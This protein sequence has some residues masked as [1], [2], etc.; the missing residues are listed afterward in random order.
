MRT[1]LAARTTTKSSP[2]QTETARPQSTGALGTR[3]GTTVLLARALLLSAVSSAS[4]LGACGDDATPPSP[5]AT[6]GAA[7]AD[8]GGAGGASGA[9]AGGCI[10]VSFT[11]LGYDPFDKRIGFEMTPS[12]GDGA[13]YRASLDLRDTASGVFQLGA[14]PDNGNKT[15]VHCLRVSAL[16]ADGTATTRFFQRAGQLTV[17]RATPGE[18]SYQLGGVT[19][20]EVAVA[21]DRTSTAVEGGRCLKLADASFTLKDQC[22]KDADCGDSTQVCAPDTLTCVPGCLFEKDC[23]SGAFC[24][25]QSAGAQAGACVEKCEIAST[26]TCPQG[27]CQQTDKS[28]TLARCVAAT[29]HRSKGESCEGNL[30]GSNCGPDLL[31]TEEGSSTA[32]D[33]RCRSTCDGYAAKPA[34]GPG[35]I[36]FPLGGTCVDRQAKVVKVSTAQVGETCKDVAYGQPCAETGQ[37]A[38]GLCLRRKTGQAL[39]CFKL[40]RAAAEC[41]AGESLVPLTKL[42]TGVASSEIVGI[43]A[44]P[45]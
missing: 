8:P 31:C 14:S 17:A 19:L 42:S 35:E 34:C 25:H 39:V 9:G 27:T 22:G 30:V 6:G 21:S 2:P 7:G 18:V 29:G 12:L 11:S 16:A 13:V 38:V 41:P 5:S 23:G 20:E 15:C 36:C 44:P 32:S 10:D 33:L 45:D 3:P 43:C 40:A 4:V 26:G 28:G 1:A 37:T 24:V